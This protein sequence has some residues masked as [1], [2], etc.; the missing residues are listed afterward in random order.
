MRD[1]EKRRAKWN[2]IEGLANVVCTIYD[3]EARRNLST[4]SKWKSNLFTTLVSSASQSWT[5]G[6]EFVGSRT[7][8]EFSG[9][10]I[11]RRYPD[12]LARQ[13]LCNHGSI[14][15]AISAESSARLFFIRGRKKRVAAVG[16]SI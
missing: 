4:E 10:I 7:M 15:G 6:G 8:G 13:S 3:Q 1:N 2:R 11:G 14:V 12:L 9:A 5:E 16:G